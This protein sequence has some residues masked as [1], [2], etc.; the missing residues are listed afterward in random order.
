MVDGDQELGSLRDIERDVAGALLLD[1]AS[2]GGEVNAGDADAD[3]VA[4]VVGAGLDGVG[5]AAVDVDKQRVEVSQ[6]PRLDRGAGAEGPSTG[7][8]ECALSGGDAVAN[9]TAQVAGLVDQECVRAGSFGPPDGEFSTT[10]H[11]RGESGSVVGDDA[12]GI[13]DQP[14][15]VAI[16]LVAESHEEVVLCLQDT[17]QSGKGGSVGQTY[18]WTPAAPVHAVVR[19][20]VAGVRGADDGSPSEQVRFG[21]RFPAANGCRGA[22]VEA[23][24]GAGDLGGVLE[25]S[26]R[27]LLSDFGIGEACREVMLTKGG[28]FRCLSPQIDDVMRVWRGQL[29]D[30]RQGSGVAG[31]RFCEPDA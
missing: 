19:F 23:G 29:L 21:D 12:L 22:A 14:Q 8:G 9:E 7:G 30:G 31:A 11:G 13:Q 4:A 18:G 3:E 5:D 1:R 10:S 20:A 27:L 6:C 16:G 2:A 28:T 25:D 17:A 24:E 15:A 26:H